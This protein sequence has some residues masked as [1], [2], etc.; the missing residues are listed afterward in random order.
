MPLSEKHLDARGITADKHGRLF[1]GDEEN[2]CIHIFSI[3][4]KFITTLLREGEQG[5]GEL[6]HICWSEQLSGLIVA[7]RKDNKTWISLVKIQS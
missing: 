7:H 4:G 2:K 5:L 6:Y 1:V 3:D